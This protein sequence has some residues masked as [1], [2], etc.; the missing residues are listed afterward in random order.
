MEVGEKMTRNMVTINITATAAEAIEKMQSERV[1]IALVLDG[2]LFKGLVTDHQIGY[3]V[4]ASRKDPT[5][6]GVSEFIT[7]EI[8]T[9]SPKTNIYETVRVMGIHRHRRLPVLEGEKPVGIIS[10]AEIAEH[11]LACNSCMQNIFGELEKT[12]KDKS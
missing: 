3:G 6:V 2:S 12:E 8:V 10:T 7:E 9:V 4:V 5:K 11:A 1:E